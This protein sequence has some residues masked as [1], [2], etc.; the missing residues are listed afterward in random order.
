MSIERITVGDTVLEVAA[1]PVQI[2][3]K[4]KAYELAYQKSIIYNSAMQ[5]LGDQ[6]RTETTAF[7]STQES[8][9]NAQPQEQSAS[10]A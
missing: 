1:L 2:Q 8:Q 3:E 7:L 9:Q 6:I 4:V 10:G 5:S